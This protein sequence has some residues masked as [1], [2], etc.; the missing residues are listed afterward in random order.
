[1][2]VPGTEGNGELRVVNVVLFDMTLLMLPT[3]EAACY[4]TSPSLYIHMG[5]RLKL[6]VHV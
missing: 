4:N 6:G 5:C 1:M 2:R 3:T